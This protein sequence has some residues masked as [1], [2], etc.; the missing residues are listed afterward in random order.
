MAKDVRLQKMLADC[1]VASRRKAE[2]MISAGE[3]KVNGVTAK[4]GDK[5]DPKKDKVIV[6]GK[7]LDT[8][9]QVAISYTTG[10]IFTHE[11][12]IDYAKRIEETGAD[13]ICIKDMAALLTPYETYDLVK[14]IKSVVKIPVQLHTHY[15]SGLASMQARVSTVKSF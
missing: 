15:T 11:Y 2:E 4:I 3:I 13:S 8:H 6:K 14:A 7:P 5:V 1:G 12:Y 9:A 10:P